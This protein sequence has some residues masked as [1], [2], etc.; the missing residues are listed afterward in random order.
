MTGPAAFVMSALL[1]TSVLSPATA[2]DDDQLPRHPTPA[3]RL[4]AEAVRR[5]ADARAFLRDVHRARALVAYVD[6]LAAPP[7]RTSAAG[8][9]P[10]HPRSTSTG[11]TVERFLACT[12]AHESDSAGGYRA[13]DGG[14]GGVENMGAYQFDQATWDATARHA[15][16]PDLVGVRPDAAS[17]ADQDTLAADLYRWQGTAPWGGR[18]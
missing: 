10:S 16:R 8:P 12:R 17:S 13:T 3:E 4:R 2:P 11:T 14:D 6:S 5:D 15:G 1:V 9:S 18:C 7:A